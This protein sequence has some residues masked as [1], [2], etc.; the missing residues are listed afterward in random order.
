MEVFL[1]SYNRR[2]NNVIVLVDWEGIE[3]EEIMKICVLHA[4]PITVV[5]VFNDGFKEDQ[6]MPNLL[7]SMPKVC[8]RDNWHGKW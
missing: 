8:S 7:M 1:K 4:T 5:K 6:E 2:S 3:E